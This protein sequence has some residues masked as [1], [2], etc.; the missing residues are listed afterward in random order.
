MKGAWNGLLAGIVVL[1]FLG[2]STLGA[3]T[4]G[5]TVKSQKLSEEE[6][7]RL[8][9][10]QE[11][12]EGL[13]VDE[14][15]PD[16]Q[17]GESLQFQNERISY[18]GVLLLRC[19]GLRRVLNEDDSKRFID[20]V[21]CQIPTENTDGVPI[22]NIVVPSWYEKGYP[23]VLQ[24]TTVLLQNKSRKIPVIV[25]LMNASGDAL[26]RFGAE[27]ARKLAPRFPYPRFAYTEKNAEVEADGVY[28]LVIQ[29]NSLVSSSPRRSGDL[30]PI[31]SA[32]TTRARLNLTD[33]YLRDE[34]PG[35]DAMVLPVLRELYEDEKSEPLDRIHAG[36]QLFLYYF[37]QHEA[38]KAEQIAEE[39]KGSS[40][41]ETESVKGMEIRSIVQEDLPFILKMNRRLYR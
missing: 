2:C 11:W 6:Q 20:A 1:G 41:L 8:S 13:L 27:A 39:L 36:M 7:S 18:E 19:L 28:L 12:K 33:S 24:I 15:D 30:P 38:E 10:Y 26:D 16:R 31:E 5:G 37:F 35:N 3:G 25:V 40:I 29:G 32:E 14:M 4:G 21:F 23:L 17:K 9:R 34:N 22:R